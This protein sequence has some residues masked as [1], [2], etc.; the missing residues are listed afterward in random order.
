M[1]TA[2]T[3]KRP[4]LIRI[5]NVDEV[6]M[7]SPYNHCDIELAGFD[8]VKLPKTGWQDKYAWSD[9]SKK[10]VLIKWDFENNFPG[11]HLFLIDIETGQTRESPRLFGLPKNISI[12]GEKVKLNK[13]LYDK[14]KSKSGNWFC[15]ID[16][17]FEFS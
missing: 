4:F 10:L 7:G 17:V 9:D 5:T 16:E 15:E 3:I 12:N 8:K 2:D 13:F 14:E 11:F 6:R 1:S